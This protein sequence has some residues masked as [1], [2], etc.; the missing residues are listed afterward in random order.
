MIKYK[1]ESTMP[2]GHIHTHMIIM[3]LKS[4]QQEEAFANISAIID[5]LHKSHGYRIR[6]H[7]VHQTRE[8][9]AKTTLAER[10]EMVSRFCAQNDMQYLAYHSPIL[11][12]SQNVW[13]DRWRKK[14]RESVALTIQEAQAVRKEAG[15]QPDKKVVIVFH[16]ASYVPLKEM[17]RTHKEKLA[18]YHAAEQEFLG[19]FAEQETDGC[20]L[21]V[22]NTY[23]RRSGDSS[24]V[25]PFHPLELGR[26]M[27]KH[28]VRTALDL[29]HYQLYSN[30]LS[31]GGSGNVAGD[32]D[33]ERYGRAPSW[34]GCIEALAGSLALLHISDA[35]GFEVKGEG[36]PVGAGEIPFAQVLGACNSLGRDLQGTIELN[37]GHLQK[38]RLQFESARWLLENVPGVFKET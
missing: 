37:R 19:L 10:A 3:Q 6:G 1:I 29:A 26:M 35:R 24:S 18:L 28:G 32:L 9:M 16:L 38:G 17:P 11:G 22:E 14:V 30:Y 2:G 7:E 20:V 27:E 31:R 36:L 5:E 12:G 4:T 34:E 21:A 33:R 23:P 8:V 13:E 15:L 25:G